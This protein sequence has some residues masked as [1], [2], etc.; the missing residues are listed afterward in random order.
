MGNHGVSI[1]VTYLQEP[2][3]S[4]SDAT[5]KTVSPV[6]YSYVLTIQFCFENFASALSLAISS[7]LLNY[8]TLRRCSSHYSGPLSSAPMSAGFTSTLSLRSNDTALELTSGPRRACDRCRRR[9]TRCDGLRTCVSCSRAHV[10]CS[11][12]EPPQR[13]GPKRRK[14]RSS[15]VQNVSSER[16]RRQRCV[17]GLSHQLN[18]EADPLLS[19]AS[20]YGPGGMNHFPAPRAESLSH[21]T[22]DD[23]SST[24]M[25]QAFK[26]STQH[27][28]Q[29]CL[30]P[31]T[32][33]TNQE[34]D[35]K[36]PLLAPENDGDEMLRGVSETMA[37]VGIES[38]PLPL[39]RS[40]F[41]PYLQLFFERLYAIFPVLDRRTFLDGFSVQ[42]VPEMPIPI[43]QYTLLNA[44]AAA[45]ITQLNC[46]VSCEPLLGLPAACYPRTAR[47]GSHPDATILPAEFFISQCLEARQ[48]SDFVETAD[49]YTVLTSFFMFAYYGNL[50][51]SRSAWYYLR[52]A[53]GFALSLRLGE[54]ESYVGLERGEAQQ[55]RRLYWLLYITE[56]YAEH[57]VAQNLAM[58]EPD[59][60]KIKGL[61]SPASER[62]HFTSF[63]R[64]PSRL[65][66][67]KSSID[68][69]I[70]CLG[71]S[72][73][74]R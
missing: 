12:E 64:T 55:R 24:S 20:S 60:T 32:Q 30:S 65:R 41:L 45:V 19:A 68:L 74:D 44:L 36:G 72:F 17:D 51:Q 23:G 69:W 11:Y 38:F 61:C 2:C 31:D 70:R 29:T 9:K 63:Y 71:E 39:P 34:S 57:V 10:A 54:S 46:P 28:D 22:T 62:R 42:E 6:V 5:Q 53:I 8:R 16:G 47:L 27:I 7:I 4:S 43:S 37:A 18:V 48:Q 33:S 56:R 3:R 58:I 26:V 35:L 1:C 50:N 25:L 13:K 40:T 14:T 59:R 15:H 67:R 73:Q 21:R 52:E 49:E 66:L